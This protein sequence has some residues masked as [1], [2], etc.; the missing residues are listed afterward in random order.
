MFDRSELAKQTWSEFPGVG[1]PIQ[2]FKKSR[3]SFAI[4]SD[5]WNINQG[6]RKI[7][8]LLHM[9]LMMDNKENQ[10]HNVLLPK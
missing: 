1:K 9:E 5:S 3:S 8:Y 4:D 2:K 6:F 10:M 7:R